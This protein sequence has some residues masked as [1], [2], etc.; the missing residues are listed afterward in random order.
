[1]SLLSQVAACGRTSAGGRTVH[2]AHIDKA[3]STKA[4]SAPKLGQRLAKSRAN[5]PSIRGSNAVLALLCACTNSSNRAILIA[6]GPGIGRGTVC[7]IQHKE[8][9]DR[10]ETHGEYLL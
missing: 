3:A 5:A 7:Q 1:M 6:V 8:T 4:L 9:E 10:L 2:S